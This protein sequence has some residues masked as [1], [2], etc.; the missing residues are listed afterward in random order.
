MMGFLMLFFLVHTQLG[1][2]CQFISEREKQKLVLN[3]AGQTLQVKV[4][5]ID[6]SSLLTNRKAKTLFAQFLPEIPYPN[7]RLLFRCLIH[8]DDII[9]S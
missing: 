4:T 3:S 7:G 2:L 5:A 6:S 9:I 1:S 8:H